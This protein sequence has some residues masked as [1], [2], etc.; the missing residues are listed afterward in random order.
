MSIFDLEVRF[1]RTR[2]KKLTRSVPENLL[3]AAGKAPC[4]GLEQVTLSLL[5]ARYRKDEPQRYR[6][7]EE[8]AGILS[9]CHERT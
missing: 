7:T 3:E 4:W 9:F 2:A 1:C 8:K 6:G 5:Q